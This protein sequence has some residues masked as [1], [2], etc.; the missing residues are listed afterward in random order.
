MPIT[1]NI[2]YR[3]SFNFFRNQLMT[4][5]MLVLLTASISVLINQLFGVDDEILGVLSTTK[6]NLTELSN[7]D[8]Q[9][10]IHHITPRQQLILLKALAVATFAALVSHTLLIGGILTLLRLVSQGHPTS[11]L[12]AIASSVSSLPRLMLLLFICNTIIQQGLRLLILPGVFMATALSLASVI[13]TT[14]KKGIFSSMK[15]S[16]KITITNVRIIVPVMVC[17]LLAKMLLFF[18]FSHLPLLTPRAADLILT[19][20]SHLVSALMLIYLFRFYMLWRSRSFNV[21]AD[22]RNHYLCM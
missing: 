8:I 5:L 17:W 7:I 1:A 21:N 15:L 12:N 6:N 11:A 14:D 19:A 18:I 22:K 4:I 13:T 3:D 20:L 9:E 2:L 16:C 10:F